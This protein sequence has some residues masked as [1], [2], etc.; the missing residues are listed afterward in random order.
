M[1]SSWSTN[2]LGEQPVAPK[3]R[4]A[5]LSSISGSRL[6]VI[7]GQDL[8]NVW[9]DDVY[10]YDL[11]RRGWVS[12]HD[13]P[14]H[15][16]TYRSV[17]VAGNLRVRL[18]LHEQRNAK[19]TAKPVFRPEGQPASASMPQTSSDSLIHLPYSAAP[20][21]EFPTDI[22]LY[23]NYNVRLGAYSTPK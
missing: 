1:S 22:Y 14:R 5:H 20:T 10:V 11:H 7:G 21:D 9:L 13:Y 23:S 19:P 2:Q 8:N 15:C 4:Y 18:P 17:A 6:F 16:G 3:P 12:A